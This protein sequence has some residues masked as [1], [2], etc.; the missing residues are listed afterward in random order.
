MKGFNR[1][2]AGAV[3]TIPMVVCGCRSHPAFGP[4]EAPSYTQWERETHRDHVDWEHRPEAEHN[5]YWDW[6]KHHQ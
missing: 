2:F 6:R 3:L 5:E 4:G 1:F